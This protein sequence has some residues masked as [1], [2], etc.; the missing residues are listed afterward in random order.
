MTVTEL[1]RTLHARGRHP[2]WRARCPAHRSK[3]L[4]LAIYADKDGIGLHCHA[5]CDR[6]DVLAALGLTWKDLKTQRDWVPTEEFKAM[7]RKEEADEK[8]RSET[9]IGQWCIRFIRKGYT[10]ENE[11]SDIAAII[12]CSVVLSQKPVRQWE[13]ILRTHLE[14]MEAARHCME[15]GMLPKMAAPRWEV[16]V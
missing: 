2:K 13:D 1:C 7:R 3:G 15:R 9:R 11:D 4:T 12:A 6:D 14:R 8:R 16:R 5:G 10:Q